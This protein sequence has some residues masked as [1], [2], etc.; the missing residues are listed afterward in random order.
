MKATRIS[1][2][3]GVSLRTIQDWIYKKDNGIDVRKIQSGRGRKASKSP[4]LQ[5]NVLRKVHRADLWR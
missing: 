4:S 5:K 1:E 2:I 3:I